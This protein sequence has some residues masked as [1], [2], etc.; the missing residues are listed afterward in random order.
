MMPEQDMYSQSVPSAANQVQR[1]KQLQRGAWVHQADMLEAKFCLSELVLAALE[2][3]L[4]A[5]RTAAQSKE[6]PSPSAAASEGHKDAVMRFALF[7]QV[8][9]STAMALHTRSGSLHL[10]LV[11][12][13]AGRVN[14]TAHE[15]QVCHKCRLPRHGVRSRCPGTTCSGSGPR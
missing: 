10:L 3:F 13:L 11:D 9:G 7:L 12:G 15:A 4:S 1:H 8:R 6:P 5:S 2:R 14:A